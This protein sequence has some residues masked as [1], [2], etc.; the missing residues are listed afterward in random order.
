MK[1]DGNVNFHGKK[2]STDAYKMTQMLELSDR[3]FTAAIIKSLKH[4]VF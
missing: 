1:K 4:A 2:Q 3:D